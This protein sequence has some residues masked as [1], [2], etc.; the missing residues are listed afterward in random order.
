MTD[1][2]V[3]VSHVAIAVSN[4]PASIRFYTEGL[5]FELG[6]CFDAGDEVAAVSEVE[7]PVRMTSQYLTKDGFR[8]ELTG[9]AVP[10]AHGEPSQT[11]NQRGLTHLSF[12]VDDIVETEARLLATGGQRLPDARVRLDR[13][14]AAIS[15][16][17]L[18]D[19]DGTRI[20]LLQRHSA[21]A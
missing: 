18:T 1:S 8:L 17:F 16:V 20:E 19:P 5:G 7:P 11:R 13:E 3:R 4:L 10:E 15:L 12:E 21:G 6:P 14:P 2:A 9:W